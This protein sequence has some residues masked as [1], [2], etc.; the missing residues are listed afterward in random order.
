MAVFPG[1]P[2]LVATLGTQPQ[3]VTLAVDLLEADE[4]VVVD[5]VFVIHTQ[6]S[7]FVGDAVTCLQNEFRGKRYRGRRCELKRIPILRPDKRP[8]VDIRTSEDAQATFHA[9]FDTIKACKQQH[10]TVHLSI[11]GGRNSMV[12][13][14]AATA[15][16]LFD[17]DDRLWHIISTAAFENTR[18]LHR[19]NPE[20]AY[21]SPVPV[22]A[23]NALLSQAI[24]AWTE[25]PF[26]AFAMQRQI[27]EQQE[28]QDRKAFL[29]T[30]TQRERE[31]LVIFVEQG[32]TAREIAQK[33]NLAPRTIEGY[34]REIYEKM[35]NFYYLR[36][37]VVEANGNALMKWFA[38]F[39][40]RR[41]D[42]RV[43][44]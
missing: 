4:N 40:N 1:R 11:A 38:G 14:G 26:Q 24:S 39:F 20:D 13:Y 34:F 43:P 29:Q 32:G 27:A 19:A 10:R 3:V 23:W 6:A 31:V 37:V 25:D 30:L 18:A 36:D 21:L 17:A 7:G 8:V 42:L 33:M 2:V 5:E 15:Q 28:D 41:P 44:S 35:R 16:I 22:L 12:A 9:I